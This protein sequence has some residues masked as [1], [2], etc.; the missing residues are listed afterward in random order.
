MYLYVI[1][2]RVSVDKPHWTSLTGTINVGVW[3][4]L[5]VF[6]PVHVKFSVHQSI[7]LQQVN[8]NTY[9]LIFDR[10][11]FSSHS[12]EFLFGLSQGNSVALRE[13]YRCSYLVQ[14]KVISALKTSK[15]ILFTHFTTAVCKAK[16]KIS[17]SFS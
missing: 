3:P 8:N 17:L 13:K 9:R 15:Q 7:F 1:M 10:K 4:S 6:S 16:K 5:S 11:L 2:L 12:V 14:G